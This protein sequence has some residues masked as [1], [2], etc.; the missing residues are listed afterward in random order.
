MSTIGDTLR[1]WKTLEGIHREG[2]VKAI[3][4]S[5]TYDVR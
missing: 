5:N 3:G 1:V 2:G 4:L